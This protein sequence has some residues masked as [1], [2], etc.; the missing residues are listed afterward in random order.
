[1]VKTLT[2]HG[3]SLALVIDKAVLELLK[4]DGDTP[5]DISTD[6]QVLVITPVH[7]PKHR[8]KFETALK[9]VNR[10]Y[11][12]ALTRLANR[13]CHRHSSACLKFW[14]VHQD[15]IERYGGESGLRDVGLLQ[16][17]A[18]TPAAGFG[19]RYLHEDLFE[20]AAAYLF[21]IVRNHPFVDG[22]KRVGAVAALVFLLLNEVEVDAD[23]EEFEQ[24]VLAVAEGKWDKP[25]VAEF[26]RERARRRRR[27]RPSCPADRAP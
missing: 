16:S 18:A 15:Q 14:R 19:G 26:L 6:G 22:N 8:K 4:I 27:G 20:M 17:A 24:A 5:L 1:M 10:R 13:A 21:H 3:N 7:D 11:G 2:R 12:Q 25:M 9:S 23:E